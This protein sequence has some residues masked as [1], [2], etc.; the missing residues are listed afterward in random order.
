[1]P[2]G[3]ACKGQPGRP[4]EFLGGSSGGRNRGAVSVSPE[5]RGLLDFR[6]G[7][8]IGLWILRA[9][10]GGTDRVDFELLSLDGSPLLA[11]AD[12][13]FDRERGEVTM[14]CQTHLRHLGFPSNILVRLTA[15]DAAGNRAL[16][17]YRLDHL[18]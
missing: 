2:A 6:P 18:V 4:D 13:P 14:A 5:G 1:M 11:F 10:L 8:K 15:V 12:I 3:I 7:A 17:E 16:C 9:D